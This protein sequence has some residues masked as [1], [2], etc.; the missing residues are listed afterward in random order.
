MEIVI[1]YIKEK[2]E[3]W[4]INKDHTGVWSF[5]F[6]WLFDKCI[7]LCYNRPRLFQKGGKKWNYET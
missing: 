2:E 7:S 1:R 4:L 6:R 3:D 5:A